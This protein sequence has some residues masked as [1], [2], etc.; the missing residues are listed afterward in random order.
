MAEVVREKIKQSNSDLGSGGY[1]LL[2]VIYS[3]ETLNHSLYEVEEVEKECD[4]L[5]KLVTIPYLKPIN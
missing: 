5:R 3:E 4:R 1:S 2:T